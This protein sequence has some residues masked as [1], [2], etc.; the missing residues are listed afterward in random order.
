MH[1]LVVISSPNHCNLIKTKLIFQRLKLLSGSLACSMVNG[2]FPLEVLCVNLIAML[3]EHFVVHEAVLE[4][5]FPLNSAIATNFRRR[6]SHLVLPMRDNF[7]FHRPTILGKCEFQCILADV[8]LLTH[9]FVLL[10]LGSVVCVWCGCV[11]TCFLRRAEPFEA[12]PSYDVRIVSAI[13]GTQFVVCD[14]T[15]AHTQCDT[16]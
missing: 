2:T 9:G 7:P 4:A 13:C 10:W 5:T 12:I 16:A 1:K 8:I 3:W 6:A 14:K 11:C 15:M